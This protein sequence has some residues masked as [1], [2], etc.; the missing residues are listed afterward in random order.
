MVDI[1]SGEARIG[2]NRRENEMSNSRFRFTW[3]AVATTVLCTSGLAQWSPLQNISR[4]PQDYGAVAMSLAIDSFHTL[5]A[6]WTHRTD[7]NDDDWIEYACRPAGVDTW[8][9]PVRINTHVMYYVGSVVVIGPGH[10][11]YVIWR[12]GTDSDYTYVSHRSGDT[13]ITEH[14]PGWCGFAQ[15]LRVS[16]LRRFRRQGCFAARRNSVAR[17]PPA[18]GTCA[19]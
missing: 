7:E 18:T 17:V 15:A 3:L 1:D 13:W 5:H 10:V 2:F 11:P 16:P 14:Q 4:C 12:S 6:C 19:W 8:T 9:I